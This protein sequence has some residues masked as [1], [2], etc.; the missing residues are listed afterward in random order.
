MNDTSSSFTYGGKTMNNRI[1]V[2]YASATGSTVDVAATIGE[3]LGAKGFSVDVQPINENLPVDGKAVLRLGELGSHG[4]QAVVLGSAIQAKR[5]LP[6]AVDFAQ[7][8]RQALNQVPVASFCV[9]F[10]FVGNETPRSYLDEAR[11][12]LQPVAEGYFAGRTDQRTYEMFFPGLPGWIRRL[13]PT[14]D[15][16]NW[17]EICAWADSLHP[18]LLQEV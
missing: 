13:I 11:S 12:L 4:Y 15:S 17:E 6:E 14:M 9:H 3:A 2:A 8:N 5:W 10:P 16:R 1:L 7:A 18:L